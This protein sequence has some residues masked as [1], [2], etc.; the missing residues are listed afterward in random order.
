MGQVADGLKI[1]V[2]AAA[3]IHPEFDGYAGQQV[4]QADVT[5]LQYPWGVPMPADLAQHDLDYYTEHTDPD[6]P[7]MTD[8]IATIDAAAL[9]SPG[10]HRLRPPARSA[11][12]FLAAP[13]DQ[14]HE[15]RTGGA[16][17]F[18]TGEG[19]YLQQFLYG[20]TG[21]RWGTDAVTVD[22]F[23][24]PQLPGVDITGVKWHGSTFDI[25][26]GRQ[27]TTLTLR[28]GPPLTVRDGNGTLHKVTRG[29]PLH[30][31]TRHPAATPGPAVCSTPVTSRRLRP[32]HR[33]LRRQSPPTAPPL[34]LYDCNRSAAQTWSLP[35][36]GTVRAMAKCMDVR[37]GSGR[38][39][40]TGAALHLQL[41]RLPAMDL[42][43][44]RRHPD[45]RARRRLPDR[46]PAREPPTAPGW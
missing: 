38:R 17:T 33:H 11:D 3:G 13:F 19:G 45:I 31:T 23:L 7:S 41:L 4:K 1:P 42:R 10:L 35:G 18:T 21:L 46:R 26:V 12:P 44:G 29:A 22:P 15:T 14:F 9:G 34:Q 5:L 43:R 27:T 2:D 24:P 8:A 25:S 30:L 36:D 16:F 6:G 20:F 40:D 37:G 28:S 39:R 32:L